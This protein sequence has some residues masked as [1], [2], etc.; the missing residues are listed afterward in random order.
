MSKSTMS[1]YW[2]CLG[3]DVRQI[4]AA[5]D[6]EELEDALR[7]PVANHVI[8]HIDV[9]GPIV[10]DD[11]LRDAASPD[12]VHPSFDGKNDRDQLVKKISEVQPLLSL[13]ASEPEM[14]SASVDDVD[15]VGC[16]AVMKFTSAP[17]M[18]T[19]LPE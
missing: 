6:V 8:F 1:W 5:L 13:Q 19:Q 3:E 12:V 18:S 7:N 4:L 9:L 15:T 16:L 11:V 10:V 2:Q 14:Y 17:S